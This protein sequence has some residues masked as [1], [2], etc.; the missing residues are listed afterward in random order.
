MFEYYEIPF[1]YTIES[2][3]GCYYD[4]DKMKTF[5]YNIQSWKEMGEKICEGTCSF[6]FGYEEYERILRERRAYR[7]KK[8]LEK[9]GKK[10]NLTYSKLFL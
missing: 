6:I 9:L 7:E 3:I 2:S 1:T 5:L 8:K 4:C 10:G